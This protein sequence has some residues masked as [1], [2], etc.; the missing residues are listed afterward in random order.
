MIAAASD[1][2]ASHM[3]VG[4]ELEDGRQVY[5]ESLIKQGFVGPDPI[6]KLYAYVHSVAAAR[7]IIIDAGLD[8]QTSARKLSICEANAGTTGYNQWQLA[9]MLMLERYGLPVPHSPNRWVCSEAA[10][11]ILYP[12]IDLRDMRRT[13]FDAV[14]PNSAWRRW[15]EIA[16]GYA[17]LAPENNAGKIIRRLS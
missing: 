16:A 3:G 11:R 17:Q 7:A 14:N 12:E 9:S 1:G 15:C 5:Y 6:D 2:W 8:A 4:F 10:A 13:T